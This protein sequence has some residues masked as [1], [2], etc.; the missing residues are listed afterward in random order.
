MADSA[1]LNGAVQT[2]K[3]GTD[4]VTAS[5]IMNGAITAAKLLEQFV[6]KVPWAH[7]DIAGPAWAE[8]EGPTH[9][10]GGTGCYVRTLVELARSYPA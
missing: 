8:D 6:G 7:L 3:L 10:A 5:A 1:I 4:A 2:A 9:D